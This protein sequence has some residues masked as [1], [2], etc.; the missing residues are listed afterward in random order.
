VWDELFLEHPRA[1]GE[2]YFQHQRR[3]FGFA[4]QL[5][6]AG[7]ACALHAIAPRL[8]V[9]AASATVDRLHDEMARHGLT[10]PPPSAPRVRVRYDG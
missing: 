5:I 3:A 1:V 9:R 6:K 10:A 8:F 2:T 4:G 7:L